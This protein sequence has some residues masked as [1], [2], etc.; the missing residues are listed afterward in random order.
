M[1]SR[2]TIEVDFNNGNLPIIQILKASSDDVRDKLI[3]AFT[4][5]LG[6]SSWCQ[7]KWEG[8]CLPIDPKDNQTFSRIVI[9]PISSSMLKEHSKV[10]LEQHELNEKY[11]VGE[12]P[13]IS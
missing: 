8:G 11:S 12:S 6:G 2:I 1:K 4:E 3:S 9:S 5:Q 7:I 10:M 13:K